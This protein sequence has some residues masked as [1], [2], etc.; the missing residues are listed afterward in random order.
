MAAYIYT[1][2]IPAV[3]CGRFQANIALAL[4]KFSVL[5]LWG[6]C[7]DTMMLLLLMLLCLLLTVKNPKQCVILQLYFDCAV[8]LCF[9][10]LLANGFEWTS[11]HEKEQM[12]T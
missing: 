4:I 11:H 2:W 1:F 3:K 8:L 5:G 7:Y 10:Y 12:I 6:D 9:C